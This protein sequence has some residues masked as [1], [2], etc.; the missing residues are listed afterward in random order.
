MSNPS[1][2]TGRQYL[3]ILFLRSVFGLA[4]TLALIYAVDAAV[5]RFRAATNRNAFST[6]TVHPY[7][8]VD[9]KDKKTEYMY[10]D[11][12]DETC[13]NSLFPHLGDSPC[14]Y[15]RRHTDEAIPN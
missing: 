7:F 4:I 5:L 3:G 2:I 8:A 9:R 12:T 6:V 1:Q 10:E 13:V 15:V 14:W 11:P